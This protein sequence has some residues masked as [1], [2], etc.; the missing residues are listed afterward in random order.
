MKSGVVGFLVFVGVFML[1][2]LVSR[3]VAL[4]GDTAPAILVSATLALLVVWARHYF[5][6]ARRQR[7]V[8]Q[9]KR[10]DSPEVAALVLELRGEYPP[11]IIEAAE[12]LGKARDRAAVPALIHVL[13]QAAENQRPGWRDVAASVADAL[14][15]IGDGR[16]LDVLYRLEN[17]RGIGFIPNIRR[18][19]AIIEPQAVLLRASSAS[20]SVQSAL[21]LRPARGG[22]ESDK[23]LL[24]RAAEPETN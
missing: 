6:L 21:L 5:M 9:A 10:P 11:Y 22:G 20:D 1:L 4:L 23:S 19:I 3:V 15:A 16:A 7:K 13:E 18:A 2:W 14:G 12:Q 24:L 17:V 8:A